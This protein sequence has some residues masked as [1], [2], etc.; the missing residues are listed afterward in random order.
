MKITTTPFISTALLC[1][2]AFSQTAFAGSLT[3]EREARTQKIEAL[4][5]IIR[6]GRLDRSDRVQAKLD[7]AR[8]QAEERKDRRNGDV[9]D[10]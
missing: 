9:D 7:L 4:Q 10:D 2:L 8:L 3:A 6:D 1:V 5:K